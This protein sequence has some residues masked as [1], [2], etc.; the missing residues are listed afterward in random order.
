MPWLDKWSSTTKNGNVWSVFQGNAHSVL[1]DL[2]ENQ[3]NCVITSP[4]YYWLRDYGVEEQIGQE[5]TVEDYVHAIASVMDEV[6]RVMQKD[7]VLFLNL[8]DTY[9]SGKRQISWQRSQ[10]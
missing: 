6:K 7:G 3:F 5:T 1:S 2:N 9:Y 10:K 8:G 4:P